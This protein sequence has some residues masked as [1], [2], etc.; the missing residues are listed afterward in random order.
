M[1]DGVLFQ[2]GELREYLEGMRQ[3]AVRSVENAPGDEV[4]YSPESVVEDV[5]NRHS[6]AVVELDFDRI[7]R[8]Q[9]TEETETFQQWGETASVRV[10][11]LSF[12][13][14][15]TGDS[16]LLRR[17]ATTFSMS[18]GPRG[19]LRGD[20]VVFKVTGQE[21]TANSV[22]GQV[23]AMKSRLS[24]MVGWA[25]RDVA[26]WT[27][28]LRASVNTAVM[29][30]KKRLDDIA[31]LDASLDIPLASS[32]AGQQVAV[33]VQRKRIIPASSAPSS[34][35]R[36]EPA[37]TNAIYEDVVKTLS[38]L[39]R[40]FERLPRTS[41][42]FNEEELRDIALFI[43][44]SSYEGAARGEV[45]NGDGKT[46][47]L[48]PWHNKNAFV[49]EC[50]FWRGPKSCADAIDQ[51]LSYLVWQDTK[52]ALILFIKDGEPSDVIDKADTC[53][54]DH[55]LFKSA[56]DNAAPNTRRDYVMVSESDS[57]TFIKVAM[58]PV[59]IPKSPIRAQA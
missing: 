9:I 34:T 37:I 36:V 28:T 21:L 8:G 46:D 23:E 29:S 26:A 27:G 30:R 55:P 7:Q 10:Q 59:V 53:F 33:P 54:R 56:A 42:K 19:F 14:P 57:Q 47:L 39:G 31:A 1:Q 49:G 4:R 15:M 6:V 3:E 16:E 24:E 45:F 12:V 40:A 11:V 2:Q 52:A 13:I 18:G 51:L 20:A 50:K 32:D 38:S 22:R 5:I 43:L 44:N 58:L 48:L 25:N 17:K 35:A 41:S